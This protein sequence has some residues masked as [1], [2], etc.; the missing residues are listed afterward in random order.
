MDMRARMIHNAV[1]GP[2]P[3]GVC[4][5]R[6]GAGEWGA[7]SRCAWC[8]SGREST[9]ERI[10]SFRVREHQLRGRI[11][12][13]FY[14]QQVTCRAH[15]GLSCRC[16]S[17]RSAE[18]PSAS[19]FFEILNLK[20]HQKKRDSGGTV[21]SRHRRHKKRHTDSG[22]DSDSESAAA[23]AAAETRAA[24]GT[25]IQHPGPGGPGPGPRRF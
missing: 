5:Q 13:G 22:S 7:W 10:P 17:A 8:H 2:C 16:S 4:E 19:A 3:I 1:E 12:S 25:L 11:R 15:S 6:M 14:E 20:K 21:P 9:R 18:P 23:A 24:R